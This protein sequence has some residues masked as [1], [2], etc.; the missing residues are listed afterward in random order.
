MTDP[1]LLLDATLADGT[2]V[3]IA[4]ADGT[5]ARVTP[6]G[7]RVAAPTGAAP[8]PGPATPAT[9]APAGGWDLDGRLVV[10]ALVNGH[11][12]LDKTFL[13]AD[14]QP[15]SPGGGVPARVRAEKALRGRLGVPVAERARLLAEQMVTLGTGTVRSHVDVD[16]EVGLDGLRAVVDLREAMADRLRIQVAAFPQSGIL[17]APGVAALLADAVDAGAEVVGGLDPDGFDDDAPAHLDVVFGVAAERDVPVDVHLH[18]L[19]ARALHQY[20]LIAHRTREHDLAGRVAISHAYGFGS[21]P[22]ADA[23]RAGALLAQAGVAVMTNGPAGPMPPVLALREEGVTVFTGSDNIRDAWWPYGDG[24]MLAVARQVAYQSGFRTDEELAVAH[25]LATG[26]AARAL[27][28]PAAGVVPGA[29]GDLLVLDATSVAEAVAAPPG[30]RWT[31]HAG[32]LV[33]GQHVTALRP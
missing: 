5:I 32:R 29:P 11:A 30:S 2:R 23:R 26:A 6:V 4:V 9:A 7:E 17:K 1:L 31:F 27:G 18:D 20:A 33:G 12:H 21:V 28:R 10:P 24:D 14:W 25:D 16:P 22:L 8:L 15:H 19:G 3:D 13:G